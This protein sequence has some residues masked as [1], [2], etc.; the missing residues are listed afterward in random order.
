VDEVA[1]LNTVER[2][3][4]NLHGE[5]VLL[6]CKKYFS[7]LG[8]PGKDSQLINGLMTRYAVA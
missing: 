2:V 4:R 6:R 1:R 5:A 7:D 3:G 8:R